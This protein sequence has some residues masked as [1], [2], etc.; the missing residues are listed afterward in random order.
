MGPRASRPGARTRSSVP[1]GSAS[2]TITVTAATSRERETPRRR[3]ASA[4]PTNEHR[5][6][7]RRHPHPPPHAPRVLPQLSSSLHFRRASRLPAPIYTRPP[8]HA[9]PTATYSRSTRTEPMAAAAT[10]EDADPPPPPP[11]AQLP[12]PR[13][14]H[15]QLQ[16][17]GY[18]LIDSDLALRGRTWRGLS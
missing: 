17:R 2:T 5:H 12:P 18:L 8:R 10:S 1:P 7:P 3:S 9:L 4:A 14:P 16:P 11:P 15:K 13:R 6:S